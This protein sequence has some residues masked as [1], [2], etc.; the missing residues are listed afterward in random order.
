[1]VRLRFERDSLDLPSVRRNEQI[2]G[3]AKSAVE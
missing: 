3:G 1:V 2:F